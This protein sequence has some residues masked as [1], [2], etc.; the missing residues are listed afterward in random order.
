MF[1]VR[2]MGVAVRVRTSIVALNCLIF[3]LWPT[4]KR[5]SSSTTSRPRSLKP[6][7]LES[8]RCVPMR[9]STRPLR[10]S[11]TRA[12]CSRGDLE[13]GQGLDADREEDH[14]VA[15]GLEVLAGQDGGRAE[16]GHL[17]AVHDRL[18]GGPHG[19]LGLAVADVAAEE[20]V[21]R[22]LALH[23]GPDLADRAELVVGLLVLEGLAEL[24]VPR[25]AGGE[26]VA[27][28]GPAPGVELDQVLGHGLD[29]SSWPASASSPRCWCRACRA[30]A[31]P[32][33]PGRTSGRG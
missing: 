8:S 26:G 30:A 22:D 1:S 5:C 18:E 20:P 13:P 6:T 12:F 7:S 2:G 9:M 31:A 16:H 29:R 19:H 23:V 25:A 24:L 28:D 27:F 32:A 15:E 33:R 21:H 14:P 10:A 4:P 3:S 11:S 17:L